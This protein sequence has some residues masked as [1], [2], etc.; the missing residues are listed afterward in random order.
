MKKLYVLSIL[1]VIFFV[2]SNTSLLAQTTLYSQNFEG[3]NFDTYTLKNAGGT[4]VNFASTG[5]DY[6]TK[7]NPATLPLGNAVTGFS[8]NVIALEDH[9]GAGFVGSHYIETNSIN[10]TNASNMSFKFRLAAPRGGDGGRYETNDV[11]TVQYAI[12]GGAFQTIISTGG[13]SSGNYYYDASNNGISGS[14]DD[15]LVNQTSQEIT[16][17]ISG[18]GSTMVIRIVFDFQGSQEEILFDDLLVTGTIT[19]STP[20][21]S[22]TSA[23][24]ISNTTTT[25]GGNVTADG[26]ATVTERGVVYSKTSV[27][28]NPLISGTGVAKNTN[29][30]GTGAF[31]KSI[32]GLSAG[33][34][35]SFKAYAINSVGTSYGTVKTFTTTGKGWTGA[36][37]TNW[38]IASNWSPATVPT[39]ADNVFVPN[40]ANKPVISSNTGAVANNITIDAGSSVTV[41]SGGSLIIDGNA[42]VNGNF[43]Y[44][45]NVSDTKWHLISSPV[46]GEQFDD[47]WNNTNG[48]NTSGTGNNE[49][50]ASYINTTDADGDWVYFQNGGTATTFGSGV[51]YSLLRTSSGDYTF[52]GTFPSPPVNTA[53]TASNL[54]NANEN[55]WT[56]IGNPFPS[57]INIASFLAAN[58]TPLTDTHESVYVWNASADS[59]NGEYQPLTTGFIHPGQGFFVSSNIAS[60][61]VTFT[62]AMQSDQ[63]GVTFYKTSNPK[64]Q[65]IAKSGGKEKTAEVNYSSNKTKGLDPRFDIGT[66]TGQSS[67]FNI[68]TQL[69]ENNEGVNFKIQALPNND[70]E[71]IIIPVGVDAKA[72]TEIVFSVNADNFTNDMKIFL[73]DREANIFIR[74]DEANSSYKIITSS[75]LNGTGRFY[76]HTKPN[77][78]NTTNLSLKEVHIYNKDNATLKILGLKNTET[79]IAIY[80]AMGKLVFS[81]SFIASSV[82]NVVLPNIANGVYLV[83]LITKEGKLSKKIILN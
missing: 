43:I 45:V 1:L 4:S 75:N 35:Y 77:T 73:E 51:G 16:K 17:S 63:N 3:T 50:I 76:L 74:L 7:A 14:G 64:I 23:S 21:V 54:G 48:I 46:A 47:T 57:H 12:N 67:N 5:T 26:G 62:K 60:T 52:T 58:T 15:V 68:Y 28:S 31:S 81:K 65:L 27:N 49:A 72:N 36:T 30:S 69:V 20:T 13:S 25:L 71:N 56:L 18:S 80:N 24:L 66:F 61:S 55:R 79:A 44:K 6:I 82:E 22:T 37:N 42:T 33:T 70:F 32:T 78:L 29:G 53:I 2:Q 83:Q 38:A 41:N 11:L 9:D 40:V 19:S 59:G 39:N 34:Q 10:I 8:G